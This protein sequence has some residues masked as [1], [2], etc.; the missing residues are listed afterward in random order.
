MLPIYAVAS[1]P[2]F[3]YSILSDRRHWSR[4]KAALDPY[5]RAS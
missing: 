5:F 1:A 2:V 4:G 3:F